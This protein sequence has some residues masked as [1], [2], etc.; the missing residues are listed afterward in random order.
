[1]ENNTRHDP[2]PDFTRPEEPELDLYT[3]PSHSSWFSWNDIH[4]TERLALKE[5]FEGTSISRTPK[6]YKEYRDFIINKYREDPSHRLNFTEIRKCLVGDVTLLRKVFCFLENWGLIN[7]VAPPR[8]REGSQ[9][10]IKVRVEDGAPNG[11]RV[12]ADPSSLRPLS[13]PVVKEKSSDSGFGEGGVKLP[14]LASYSDVFGD[15]KRLR[16]GN[17]GDKCDSEYYEYYKDNFIV[18]VKCFKSGNYGENKSVDD[19]KLKDCS[20]NTVTTGAVWTEEETLLL[21]ESVLRHGDNWDLVARDV[22]TKSKLDCITKLVE[23]P[24]GGSLIDSINGRATSS[25]PTT[26]LNGAKPVP[27][28]SSEH[29]ENIRNEDQGQNLGHGITN[30]NEQNGDSENQEPPLKKKRTAPAPD[31]DSSLMKQVALISTMVGPQ[32]TAAAAEAAVTVLSDEMVDDDEDSEM[33]E[34]S[35]PSETQ[36]MSPEKNDVPLPLR[37]RA[38]VATGLGAAAAHSKLL[39]DQEER[40]IEHLVATIIE[41]QFKKLHSKIKHCEEAEQLMEKE[42]AAI[43][44]I[45]EYILE[46]RLNILQRTYGAGIPKSREQG[47]VQS[48]TGA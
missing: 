9:N 1:M 36:E 34:R 17:C 22:Q 10:D 27:V 48:Q 12:V 21:L 30:E 25:G 44:E 41:A 35:S 18:C 15:L 2:N 6:I 33:K 8:P 40:E 24:F 20:G 5:F 42:Y 31:A 16:C 14:P 46:E 28:P 3:I 7:F 39:A 26:N 32:I 19:F 38:A 47:A 29:Q 13:A 37:I 23:L 43:E 4:E 11:V 45:K